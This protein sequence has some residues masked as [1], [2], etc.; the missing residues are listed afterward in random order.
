V[1]TATAT[2][3]LSVEHLRGL[4]QGLAT[5]PDRWRPLVHH[6]PDQRG[7]A[8][9]FRDEDVEVWVLSWM[10]GQDTG[11]HDHGGS[12]AAIYVAEGAVREDRLSFSGPPRGHTL[13]QQ[14]VSVVPALHIHRVRHSGTVPAV[15][16]H[17]Y[18]PPLGEVGVYREDDEGLIERWVQPGEHELSAGE[19]DRVF[20]SR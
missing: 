18:S 14:D 20:E 8:L 12:S 9:L 15:S 3:A 19:D 11:Y 10:P 5:N 13:S 1:T 7:V 17:A 2:R 6:D 16:I 4:V